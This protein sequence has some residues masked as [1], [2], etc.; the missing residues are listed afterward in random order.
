AVV[1]HPWWNNGAVQTERMVRYGEGACE[2]AGKPAIKKY[3]YLDFTNTIETLFLLLLLLPFAWKGGWAYWIGAATGSVILAELL[4]NWLK[5]VKAGK[6]ASP[7]VA[8][9][10]FW[11]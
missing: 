7:S 6:T 10:L 8:F 1:Q 11:A 3:T 5:A 9:H 2:M 4:T